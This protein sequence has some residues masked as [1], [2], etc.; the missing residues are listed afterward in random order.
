M[1]RPSLTSSSLVWI[2]AL[3][4]S[5]LNFIDPKGSRMTTPQRPN[6]TPDMSFGNII[7]IVTL[8]VGIAL[9]WGQMSAQI[10][11]ERDLREADQ[12]QVSESLAAAVDTNDKVEQRLRNIEQQQARVDERFTMII[13]LMTDLKAQVAQL[14]EKPAL[15]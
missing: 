4:D 13:S 11:S 10:S 5:L 12:E 7:T 15:K 1:P 14:A 3:Y 2:T 9:S 8:V 6:F